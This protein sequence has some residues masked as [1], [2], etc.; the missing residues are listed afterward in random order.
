MALKATIFK[1]DLTVSDITRGY[2]ENHALTIARHPSETDLR[3]LVRLAV[4]ALNAHE[5]LAFTKGLSTTDEPDL[6]QKSLTGEIELWIDLGQ[7]IDKR[8]RQSCGKATKVSIYTYQKNTV[9]MWYE[10]VKETAERFKNLSVI[11]LALSDENLV[12]RLI[13][14]TMKLNC[15]IED[16]QMQLSNDSDTLTIQMNVIKAAN[17]SKGGW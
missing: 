8:I 2:Y 11:H 3:M 6:W 14:R 9:N 13:D 7:P 12:A 16:D 17:L 10:T 5:N 4:F 15:V 1:L